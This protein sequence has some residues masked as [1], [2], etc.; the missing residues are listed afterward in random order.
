MH[1]TLET[2]VQ[3]QAKPHTRFP[4]LLLGLL[5]SRMGNNIYVLA[6]P[7]IAYDL[8][9]SSVIMGTVFA[10]EMAPFVILLPFGGVIIDRLDR[11]KIMITSDI[12]R[13]LIVL[14]I[15]IMHW[16]GALSLQY[17][18]V[19]SFVLS[20]LSFFV[21]V[22]LLATVPKL[23]PPELLTKFNG[24]IQLIENFARLGG[25]VLAGLLI[26]TMG[27]YNPLLINACTYLAMAFCLFLIG[28]FQESKKFS[29]ISEVWNDM[30]DGFRYLLT[31]EN[32]IPI[33]WISI[34]ANFGLALIMSTLVFYLRDVLHADSTRT[35]IVYAAM[36]IFG[37][38]GSLVTPPL[39][40]KI[41]RGIILCFLMIIGGAIGGVLIAL[42]PHWFT[43]ALGLGILGGTV[44]SMN[45]ILNS[46]KQETIDNEV[47]GRVEGS[48]T[49]VSYLSIPLGGLLAGFTMHSLGSAFTYLLAT[50]AIVV[51]GLICLGT[52][53]RKI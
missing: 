53:L 20:T 7:W 5:L 21:D 51:A 33:G 25:P 44:T 26:G 32:L 13:T 8:T 37:I 1:S 31:G 14:S 2:A 19:L 22:S 11:R 36:G 30:K 41:K 34:L 29:H 24:R 12:L 42:I 49:S 10:T 6:L 23:V 40:R 4:L 52:P 38:L 17:I 3:P 50:G 28:K 47:F 18:Y 43:L 27:T 15:P 35:G 9:G 48:L 39:T 46:Y 16:T 45:I